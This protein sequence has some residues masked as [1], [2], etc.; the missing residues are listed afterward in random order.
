MNPC[1][2]SIYLPGTHRYEFFIRYGKRFFQHMHLASNDCI[3]HIL[4]EEETLENIRFLNE[5]LSTKRKNPE[6]NRTNLILHGSTNEHEEAC[7]SFAF[8]YELLS[9]DIL[10][11]CT[12][13]EY[14]PTKCEAPAWKYK[15]KC[16]VLNYF[17]GE[18]LQILRME[19]FEHNWDILPYLLEKHYVFIVIPCMFAKWNFKFARDV[20]FTQHPAFPIHHLIWEAP[21]LNTHLWATEYG[22]PS[23]LCNN[24]C[25]LDFELFTLSNVSKRYDMVMNCRPERTTKRPYLARSVSNLAYIKGTVY[26]PA[27]IY[28]VSE[29][30]CAFVNETRLTPEEVANIY[31]QS[32]CGGI[33]SEE[34]GACYSSSE[35]LLCGLPVVSTSSRGGRDTWYTPENSILV[36]PKETAVKEAVDT[37]VERAKAGLVDPARIRAHHIQLSTE[38]RN[39]FVGFVQTLFDTH[40]IALSAQEH[41]RAT[42]VHKMKRY[43]SL[44]VAIRF[45]RTPSAV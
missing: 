39:N 27:D 18:A 44:E 19:G 2:R 22:F 33:F 1:V 4:L 20:L 12:A 16:A 38:M 37:W 21:D 25:W 26:R 14:N 28:D 9:E 31:A 29:L 42:Y 40:G 35:Y 41:F 11:A 34:E 24:N 15:G 8:R 23:I 32:V 10:S 36:E 7:R 43:V 13:P 6:F 3:Y 5:I 45:L 30:T 17:H